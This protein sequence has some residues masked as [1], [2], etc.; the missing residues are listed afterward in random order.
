MKIAENHVVTLNYTLTDNDG[1][2]IDSEFFLPDLSPK[3][4][5]GII[6]LIG[7]IVVSIFD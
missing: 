2:V 3:F 5:L 4:L 6:C 7:N 1:E